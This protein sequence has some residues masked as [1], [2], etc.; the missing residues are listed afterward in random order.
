MHFARPLKGV[1]IKTYVFKGAFRS[2]RFEPENWQN[3]LEPYFF[4]PNFFDDI[5]IDFFYHSWNNVAD[6][7]P[8]RDFDKYVVIVF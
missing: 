2:D 1:K 7:K 6:L 4:L 3:V 8:I 5:S